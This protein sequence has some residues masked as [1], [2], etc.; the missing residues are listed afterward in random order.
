[1]EIR[2]ELLA[3]A[4]RIFASRTTLIREL[5][6]FEK[7]YNDLLGIETFDRTIARELDAELDRVTKTVKRVNTD[8]K[9]KKITKN[10]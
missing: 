10:M 3:L 9:F 7:L 4:V 2:T 6:P 5:S 8:R 1:M